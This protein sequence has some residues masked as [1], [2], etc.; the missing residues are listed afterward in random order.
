MI[1]KAKNNKFNNLLIFAKAQKLKIK[2]SYIK[3]I[4]GTQGFKIVQ[5]YQEMIDMI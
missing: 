4:T 3:N 1:Y 2:Y 5:T